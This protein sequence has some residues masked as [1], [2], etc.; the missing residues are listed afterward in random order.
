[1]SKSLYSFENGLKDSIFYWLN[2]F[3]NVSKSDILLESSI[4]FPLIEYLERKFNAKVDLEVSHP[5]FKNKLID[6]KYVLNDIENQSGYIE[7]KFLRKDTASANARQR[8]FND[9]IRLAALDENLVNYFILCG[10]RDYFNGRF[11]RIVPASRQ[12][13]ILVSKRNDSEKTPLGLYSEWFPF[14]YSMTKSIDLHSDLN[15]KYI[16]EF[17]GH[18]KEMR[19]MAINLI[20]IKLVVET[21]ECHKARHV[22]YIWRIRKIS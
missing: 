12:D 5:K 15:E 21:L 13:R 22:V 20:E 19:E 8:I 6:F 9:I 1:M 16:E 14:E 4:R 10:R 17:K 18:Y 7:L 2:Y 11:R 3:C